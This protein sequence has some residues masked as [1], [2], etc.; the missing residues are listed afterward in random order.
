MLAVIHRIA[1]DRARAAQSIAG[2]PLVVRQLLALRAAGARRIALE[3]SPSFRADEAATWLADAGLASVVDLVPSKQPLGPDEVARR[4]GFAAGEPIAALRADALFSAELDEVHDLRPGEPRR[5]VLPA[6]DACK[7][8]SGAAITLAATFED[9]ALVPA[10]RYPSRGWAVAIRSHADALALTFA[11]LD[12]RLASQSADRDTSMQVDAVEREPGVW[13]ARGATVAQGAQLV[14][15]VLVGPGAV[16]ER[17]ASVGPKAI[18]ER[19][20]VIQRGATVVDA[21]VFSSTVVGEGVRIDDLGASSVGLVDLD[22]G[23]CFELNDEAMLSPRA[24]EL[25]VGLGTRAF[26]M[27]LLMA[28]LPAAALLSLVETVRGRDIVRLARRPARESDA[29]ALEPS[30][31]SRLLA[32]WLRL[33]DVPF[34]HRALVGVTLTSREIAA[35]HQRTLAVDASRAV[36]GAFAIDDALAVEDRSPESRLRA[37]AWYADAKSK[38]ADL[39]LVV[40][41][42]RGRRIAHE[43]A[44]MQLAS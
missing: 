15:P 22:S 3:C 11:A 2:K 31:R 21:I 41:S 18:L 16:V 17:G 33:V 5:L 14:G 35:K 44:P 7:T 24:R 4:A 34:G 39:A 6:P 26:A 8:L 19:D 10:R 29:S 25:E 23:K 36:P 12:G 42:M 43:M 1:D 28:L 40:R 27:V 38:R 20:V 37:M 13:I 32:F 30:T 9:L